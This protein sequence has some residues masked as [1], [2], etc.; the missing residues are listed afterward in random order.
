MK[1]IKKLNKMIHTDCIYKLKEYILTFFEPELRNI[2]WV[3]S[4]LSIYSGGYYQIG[5]LVIVNA[6][7]K[8]S[9]AGTSTRTIGHMPN[10]KTNWAALTCISAT[11]DSVA[12]CYVHNTDLQGTFNNTTKTYRLSGIYIA[13]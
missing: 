6:T 9:S 2:D 11:D 13:K 1:I 8:L 12:S 5:K 3:T 7:F 4:I 10:P